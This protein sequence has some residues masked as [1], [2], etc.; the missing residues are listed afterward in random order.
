MSEFAA[1]D[2]TRI[3]NCKI[4][5][6]DEEA[7]SARGRYA[8]LCETHRRIAAA[9]AAAARPPELARANPAADRVSVRAA[10]QKLVPAA[11]E[12]DKALARRQSARDHA[13]AAF[14]EFKK[15]LDQ[16]HETAKQA[17]A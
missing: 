13:R 7:I 17:I 2:V 14:A 16:L 5:G 15:A 3:V 10:A 11:G 9:D 8:K 6:C 1:H 12:L 4:H